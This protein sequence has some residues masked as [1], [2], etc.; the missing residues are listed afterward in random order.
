MHFIYNMKSLNI[1]C[2]PSE[3]HKAVV[4]TGTIMESTP[5]LSLCL[6]LNGLLN[7]PLKWLAH[8]PPI[9]DND[10]VPI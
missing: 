1:Q 5:H 7:R 4:H 9:T 10:S 6:R 3:L 8:L 2:T